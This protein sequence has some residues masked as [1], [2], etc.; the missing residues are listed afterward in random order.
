MINLVMEKRLFN[1]R[2]NIGTIADCKVADYLN[3]IVEDTK[4]ALPENSEVFVIPVHTDENTGLFE[5]TDGVI[6]VKFKKLSENAV[7][8][9]RAKPGDMCMD[10]TAIDVEY[11]EE[12]D[13]YVYHTGLAFESPMGTGSFLFVRSSNSKT[14]CYLAN[15]VGVAD[16]AGYRGEI[17]L[18][19][20]N[21]T[22]YEV[23]CM[24]EEW[25]H[26]KSLTEGITFDSE[27]NIG[28]TVSQIKSRGAEP[29]RKPDPME[30]LPYKVGDRVGQI[31]FVKLPSV[32][33]TE[34]DEL[35][36]SERGTGGFGHTGN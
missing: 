22:S 33:L 35:S 16:I 31:F 26:M 12:K 15:H 6:D 28:E 13:A 2:V 29:F 8:P 10:L 9:K 14:D 17:M 20:K 4:K 5:V 30:F 23:R 34:V 3:E 25:K 36:E 27:K 32:T 21:R 1:L 7:V 18:V 11:D 19:F 24:L